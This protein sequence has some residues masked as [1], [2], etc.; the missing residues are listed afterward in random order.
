MRA[1]IIRWIDSV[2]G[3]QSRRSGAVTVG[4]GTTLAWRRIRRAAG[5]R[6]SVGEDSIVHAEISFEDRGGEAR[7]GNRSYIGRSNLVCLR[8]LTIGDDVIISWGVTVVDHDSHS[9][10]WDERRDDVRNWAQGRKDWSQVA[11]AP[12]TICDKAWIGFNVS[13]LKGVTVGEGAVVGAC[14]VVTRD[15]PAFSLAAGNPA[16]VIRTLV[17]ST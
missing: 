17:H 8:E 2:L 10:E 11:H 3:W 12:V 14:S 13:I 6:L 1:T 7:I 4:R 16:R 15:V 9:L 5:N